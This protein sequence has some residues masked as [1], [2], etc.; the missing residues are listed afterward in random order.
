MTVNHRSNLH[1][2]FLE[3]RIV[4]NVGSFN[5]LQH[6]ITLADTPNTNNIEPIAAG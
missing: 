2:E 4:L 3:P 5:M 6:E 1:L